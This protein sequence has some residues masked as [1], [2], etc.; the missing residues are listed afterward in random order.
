MDLETR[1]IDILLQPVSMSLPGVFPT[2]EADRER[3]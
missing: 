2:E 1:S 3:G